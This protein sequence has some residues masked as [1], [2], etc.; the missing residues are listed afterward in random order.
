[1]SLG[2]QDRAPGIPGAATV[3]DG[4]IVRDFTLADYDAAITLWRASEGIG[5]N[6]SDTRDAIAAFLDRNPHLSLAAFDRNRALVGAVLCGHDGRRG[7]LHHLAVA[8]AYR[9]KGLGRALA[10]S[11]LFR[12]KALGILK[13]TIFLYAHNTSGRAFWLQH[14]WATRDDLVVVQRPLASL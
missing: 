14:G 4:V 13:C 3:P 1:M 12:L 5:L 11:C 7:Y 8:V 6:E 2:S 9:R 10:N